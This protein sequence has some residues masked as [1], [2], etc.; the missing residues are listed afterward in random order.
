MFDD[1][2]NVLTPAERLTG[3]RVTEELLSGAEY[4]LGHVREDLAEE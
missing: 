3:V 1:K 2:V 4:L